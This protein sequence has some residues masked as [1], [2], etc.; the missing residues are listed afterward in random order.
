MILGWAPREW[1]LSSQVWTWSL[2][3]G[4]LALPVGGSVPVVWLAKGQLGAVLA[5]WPVP[6][7]VLIPVPVLGPGVAQMVWL[8]PSV[9]QVGRALAVP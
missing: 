3:V 6:V 8:P 1:D 9:L 4:P 7:P 2:P 5:G